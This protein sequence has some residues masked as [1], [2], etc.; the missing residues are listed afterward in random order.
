MKKIIFALMMVVLVSSCSSE[1]DNSEKNLALIENYV[2]AVE[3]MDFDAMDLYL[4]DNYLGLGPSYGDSI[5]KTQA[6][7][8]WKSN[9]ETLYEK[10][11]YD[12]SRNAAIKIVTGDNQGDWISNWAE[13]KIDYKNNRGSVII[14]ANSIY[15]IQNEKIVK[16]YTF[17]NEAD[18]LGQ[19]GY[20]FFNPDDF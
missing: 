18:V 17:Y 4:D 14:W 5:N 2:K 1:V 6:I 7:T 19:L 9:V 12:K 20:T 16:S 13:L 10:I 8:N 15:Q 11:H 3:N